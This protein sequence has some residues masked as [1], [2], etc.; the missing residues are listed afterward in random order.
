MPH[1]HG[2]AAIAQLET[3]LEERD[4]TI[5]AARGVGPGGAAALPRTPPLEAGAP[6][7]RASRVGLATAPPQPSPLRAESRASASFTRRAGD[8]RKIVD[9]APAFGAAAGRRTR[10]QV[11]RSWSC[12]WRRIVRCTSRR[13]SQRAAELNA[14]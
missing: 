10:I 14:C 2:A 3:E 9:V 13:P 6:P 8:A 11:A 5:A 12:R 1:G 7:T 4:E